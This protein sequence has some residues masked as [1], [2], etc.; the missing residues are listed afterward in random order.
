MTEKTTP[1]NEFFTNRAEA[2]D[3]LVDNEF[4]VSRGKFY[5]D[6]KKGFPA[7]NADKTISKY[8]VAVYGQGL[9]KDQAPDLSALQKSGY[10]HRKAKADAKIAEMKAMQM[11]REEDDLW[12]HADVAWSVIAALLGQIR[13]AIRHQQHTAC[14]EMVVAVGG[15]VARA[16]ELFE[17]L[18][19]CVDKAFNEVAGEKLEVD[20]EE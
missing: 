19:G 17:L 14:P 9:K 5:D 1:P 10:D 13:E 4:K 18:E 7:I 8:Q 11:E 3:W 12:L 6:C 2:H 16:P 15:A 20:W